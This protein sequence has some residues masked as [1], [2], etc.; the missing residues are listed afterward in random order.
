M[1]PKPKYRALR[2]RVKAVIDKQ[3]VEDR[4]FIAVEKYWFK[5]HGLSDRELDEAWPHIV[6]DLGLVDD[7]TGYDTFT[8][9]GHG[10]ME[11]VDELYHRV[12]KEKK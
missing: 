4:A 7:G 2:K 10:I 12:V 9:P 8:L 5:L 1:I 11:N 3:L 6:K